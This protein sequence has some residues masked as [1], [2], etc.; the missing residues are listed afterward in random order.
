MNWWKKASNIILAAA[1]IS[2]NVI[3]D[4]STGVE[5]FVVGGNTFPI[6][7]QL[8]S[9]RFLWDNGSKTWRKSIKAIMGDVALQSNIEQLGVPL[10]PIFNS[11]IQQPPPPQLPQQQV[12]PQ[13]VQNQQRNWILTVSK[14]VKGIEPGLPLVLTQD[15]NKNWLWMDESE[16]TGVIPAS[17]VSSAVESIRDDANKVFQSTYPE[18]LFELFYSRNELPNEE[19]DIDPREVES[20]DPERRQKEMIPEELMSDEQRSIEKTF[21]NGTNDIVINALAGTG[22]TSVLKHLAWKFGDNSQKW[23]Y[24]VFNT[25]NGVEAKEKFPSF[26]KV[27]TTNSFLGKV[28]N[29]KF[30]VPLPQG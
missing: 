24:L 28:I 30:E 23:L 8:K 29:S 5:V 4:P 26:V 27:A 16:Q 15:Q 11:N 18:Q 10:D 21:G 22:K 1:P 12:Q 14:N 25:K 13:P 3:V 6:K 9:M 17:E 20:V 2:S 19:D 7:E